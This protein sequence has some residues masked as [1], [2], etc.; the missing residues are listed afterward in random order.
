[1]KTLILSMTLVVLA[2][3]A[4]L[5]GAE[6]KKMTEVDI[7]ALTTDTQASADPTPGMNL[8]WWIPVEF[9]KALLLQDETLAVKDSQELIQAFEP[10]TLVAAVRAD[11]GTFGTFRYHSDESLAK[12]M[13]VSYVNA[14]GE[15]RL[16]HSV[17]KPDKKVQLMLQMMKPILTA[18]MGDLGKNFH[19]FIYRDRDEKGERIVDPY[20]K[21]KLEIKLAPMPGETGGAIEIECPVNSLFVPRKCATCK[22][23]AHV[24]WNFCPWCGEK[25]QEAGT[26]ANAPTRKSSDAA[27]RAGVRP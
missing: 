4:L 27:S 19:F 5:P 22:K 15:K 25:W 26:D 3:A 13:A 24:S 9:W 8:V 12:N 10:Y 14:K 6:P 16:M 23:E 17:S 21:G 20:K 7:D 2:G 1:M 11:I 18:A